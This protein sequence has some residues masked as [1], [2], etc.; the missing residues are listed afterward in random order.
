MLIFYV[1]GCPVTPPSNPMNFSLPLSSMESP[2]PSLEREPPHLE[3]E[4]IDSN[5]GGEGTF[6]SFQM[7]I[8]YNQILVTIIIIMMCA[9]F[10]K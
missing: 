7:S 9:L 2:T 10:W 1:A 8:E 3:S 5:K 6:M 4:S